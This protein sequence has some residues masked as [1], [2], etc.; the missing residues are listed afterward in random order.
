M[1]AQRSGGE[2]PGFDSKVRARRPEPTDELID[3]LTSRARTSP[4]AFMRSL[5]LAGTATFLAILTGALAASGALGYAGSVIQESVSQVERTVSSGP[6]T[7]VD[8]PADSQYRPGKGCG[9]K[10]HLHDRRFECKVTI[11]DV[12][13]KEG[14]S[15]TTA[16]VFTV[17]LDGLAQDTVTVDF[18]TADGSATA[19]RDYGSASGSLTFNVGESVKS[20]TVLAIA[21]ATKESSETFSVRLNNPSP[22]AFIGDDQG[23]GTI[24]NDD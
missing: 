9:D 4:G 16:A 5:R 17:S 24:K 15:G 10:N 23:L 1:T 20:V 22:N 7:V 12:T 19:S 6:E 18:T 8:S 3:R 14:N 13:V 11:N 21:D 2:G